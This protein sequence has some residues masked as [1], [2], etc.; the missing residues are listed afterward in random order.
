MKFFG[1][2]SILCLVILVYTN[3]SAQNQKI[4]DSLYRITKNKNTPDT[5]LIK[6]F[7]D[8]GIQYATSNSL[9]AKKQIRTA[10]KI[11]QNINKPRGMAGSYNCLGVV[12]Y[13]QKEYDSALVHFEKA[14]KINQE[15]DHSWGQASAF[16]QIG[17]VHNHLNQYYDAIESFNAAGNIFISLNDSISYIKSIENTG[18]SYSLMKYQKKAL[19][20]YIKANQLYEKLKNK[21]GIARTYF[22]ISNILI[23]QEEYDKALKYLEESLPVIRETG[24]KTHLSA[25]LRNIGISYNGL[26]NHT[27]AL[28]YLQ[29]S[30]SF[31]IESPKTIALIESDI[32]NTYY[33]MKRYNKGLLHLKRALQN[34]SNKGDHIQKASTQNYIAKSLL[35]LNQ[36]DSAN[37]YAEKSLRSAKIA[38]DLNTEKEANK[39]LALLA[40]K[41]NNSVAAYQYYKNLSKIKDSLDSIEKKAQARVLE[42][43]FQTNKKELKIH[44]LEKENEYAKSKNLLLTLSLG[45]GV[46]TLGI[47][48]FFFR[49][50]FKLSCLEKA[51]LSKELDTKNK[52]LTTNS[53]RL[54]KKNKVLEHLK[55]EVEVMRFAEDQNAQYNYQKVLQIINFDFKDDHHWDH[56]KKH[57]EQIHKD[58]YSKIKNQYPNVTTNE[59]RLMALLKM[60]LSSKEIATILNIT[61]EGVRKARYR[62]RKKLEIP[63]NNVLIDIILNL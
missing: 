33:H 39:T 16:H 18:V 13:Y 28:S 57:F 9:L 29:K 61:Q 58:F 27:K 20:Y 53:L 12:Y 34:F 37:Y 46:L 19:E 32:G 52:E 17:V 5:T 30:L 63:S 10:L 62:L 50:K 49:K 45:I 22:K 21:S 47:F 1:A 15:I 3:A 7:N 26:G 40:E 4:V 54:V 51:L 23:K 36:L 59:L 31:R 44:E 24:N 56:F 6:A 14:L 41:S 60:N 2:R 11:A 25:T 55:E 8:L 48:V 38:L 35:E 43:Q 42:T